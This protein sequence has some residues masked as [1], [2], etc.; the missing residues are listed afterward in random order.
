MPPPHQARTTRPAACWLPAERL[1][2]FRATAS[3]PDGDV[4]RLQVEVRRP[5]ETFSGEPTAMSPLAPDGGIAIAQQ[6]LEGGP[7][8]WRYRFMDDQGGATAWTGFGG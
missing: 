4:V 8:R 3:D 2:T 6:A 5:D 1:F 7:W